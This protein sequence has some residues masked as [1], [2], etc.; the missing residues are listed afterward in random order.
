MAF[1]LTLIAQLELITKPDDGYQAGPS[2]LNVPLVFL[3]TAPVALRRIVPL[4][5]VCVMFGAVIVPSLFTAHTLLFWGGLLPLAVALYSLARHGH[6]WGSRF[7]WIIAPA[8]LVSY[9]IH[10]PAARSLSNTVFALGLFGIAWVLGWALRRY[11]EQRVALAAAL[12]QLEAGQAERER[13]A[14][15]AE[16]SRIARELHD[17]VA[18]S[19]SVMVVQTGA[20]RMRL[21]TASAVERD[22]LMAVEEVG[23]RAL[24]ELRTMLGILRQPGER[25][26]TAPT[27]GSAQLGALADQFARSG[28]TIDL[29]ID[30]SVGSLPA[31]LQLSVFRIVQEALT[32][33]LKHAGPV[34]ATVRV[35]PDDAALL[36]E[37]SN[38]PGTRAGRTP[39][40]G[41]H[42]LL[43]M[44][45]RAGMFGGSLIAGPNS[46]GGYSVHGLIPLERTST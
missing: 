37:I 4:T 11:A 30:E 18:H 26:E 38:E 36:I 16:R 24:V 3:M 28:L 44:S 46:D 19:V 35:A 23:R 45:E 8:M 21:P 40:A 29:F 10:M 7:G 14:V 39:L 33:V 43:G 25:A 32:N 20:T 6:G 17:V 22:E 12:E 42:G 5:T 31:G 13:S 41:G 2:W 1:A 34:G 15:I 9:D 27:P